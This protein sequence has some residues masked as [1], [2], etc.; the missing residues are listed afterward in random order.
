MWRDKAAQHAR[1]EGK[2]KQHIK[3]RAPSGHTG[4]EAARGRCRWQHEGQCKLL[5]YL[6]PWKA[7]EDG[8][9]HTTNASLQK[10]QA[11]SYP[12]RHIILPR[13]H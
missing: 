9:A 11:S 4:L 5:K 10:G 3:Q 8:F 7:P 2:N 6:T 12:G 13:D 1:E